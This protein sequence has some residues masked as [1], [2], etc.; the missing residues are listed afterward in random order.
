MARVFISHSSKDKDYARRL[1]RDLEEAGHQPWLD[2][3]QIK[4]GDCIVERVERAIGEADHLAIVLTG[5]S[6]SSGWV[7]REW[8]AKYWDEVSTGRVAVLPLLFESCEIPVLLKTKKY[9]DFRDDRSKGLYDLLDA[10]EPESEIIADLAKMNLTFQTL[11][12]QLTAGPVS[13]P[14]WS[15]VTLYNQLR[16]AVAKRYLLERKLESRE[17]TREFHAPRHFFEQLEYLALRDLK[18]RNEAF[19]FLVDFRNLCLH[20]GPGHID[21]LRLRRDRV[22][23]RLS[24]LSDVMRGLTA[25]TRL[26]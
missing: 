13:D 3:W 2:E 14:E 23:E 22:L 11:I 15:L 7:S 5:H 9:A 6:V 18:V 21:E 25:T 16:Q 8:K 1:A 20:H 24:E 17:G 19:S 10:L 26:K 4:V 12:E